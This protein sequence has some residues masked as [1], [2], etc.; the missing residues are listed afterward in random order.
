[1][2]APLRGRL[3]VGRLTLDQEV[4]V[5]IPAPQLRK[6]P[7][8]AGFS[9]S[10]R[11]RE[12]DGRFAPFVGASLSAR[13]SATAVSHVGRRSLRSGDPSSPHRIVSGRTRNPCLRGTLHAGRI[14]GGSVMPA[15]RRPARPQRFHPDLNSRGRD[16]QAEWVVRRHATR[17]ILAAYLGPPNR[18][19][20]LEGERR[21]CGS[22]SAPPP[23][24]P[25]S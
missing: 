12:K 9:F 20:S 16:G 2:R 3:M 10:P 21:F 1:M 8:K 19:E 5:R 14:P 22:R 11:A 15:V 18:P 25:R 4:G 17:A 24:S 6:R 23:P 7:A 13:T